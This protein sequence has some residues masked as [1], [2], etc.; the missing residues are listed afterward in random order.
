[1]GDFGL[2]AIRDATGIGRQTGSYL[3]GGDQS[4]WSCG[5]LSIFVSLSKSPI[6]KAQQDS[7]RVPAEK[8]K[9]A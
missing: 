5:V 1:M 7:S 6:D 4:F 8:K 3:R 9:F 2:A